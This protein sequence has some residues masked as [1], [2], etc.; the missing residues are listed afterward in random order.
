M[1]DGTSKVETT[2]GSVMIFKGE[3]LIEKYQENPSEPEVE[4]KFL[5]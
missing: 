4:R 3:Q 2:D 5:G 1:D